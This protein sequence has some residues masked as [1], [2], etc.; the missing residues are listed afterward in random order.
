MAD[1]LNTYTTAH[2]AAHTHAH[3]TARPFKLTTNFTPQ[4]D[5][6]AAIDA[7]TEGLN[8]GLRDQVLLGVTGSG[9]T[10]T[11]ANVIERIQMPAL[12]IAHNK[13]LAAQL[14]GELKDLFQE[15]SVEYFVSYYDY[16]QPEAYIPRSDT[17][18]EK[19]SA[20]NDDIDRMRH[21]ATMAVLER[22]DAI[23]VASVSCIYGI[24]SPEDYL[25]MHLVVQEGAGMRRD[26]LVK[27]L[28]GLQY[29]REETEFRRGSL[30]V[31][32]DV[33]EVYPSFSQDKG[34]RIEFFGDD[35]D[36]LHEFDPMT[37]RRL[38]RLT[39]ASIYPNTHWVTPKHRIKAALPAI[40]AEMR[41]RV[42]FFK[43]QG[44]AVEAHRIAQRTMFDL[45]MLREFG[46]C[47]GIENYSRHLSGRAPG[48]P[49]YSLMDYFP[50]DFLVVIDE[51]HATVP[52]IGG[53]YEGDRSRKQTLIDYGFR[54]PSALDNR[55]LRFNE[56]EAR[57]RRV[58]YVS[59]TPG[60]YELEKSEGRVIEQII[61]PT[62]LIDPLVVI[63]PVTHQVEDL[64]G[65]IRN[66]LAAGE[67]VLATTL[68]KKMSED[69]C[70]YYTE[71]GIATKYLHSDID[72]L[73]RVKI[74]QELRL[75]VFDVLIGV[76]LLR[77]GLDLP[78]VS[79]VA[80]LDAD[81]EGFLRSVNSLIQ[82]A[83]R[84]ARN[85]NGTVILYADRLT[86]SIQRMMAETGRRRM[87]QLEYNRRMGITPETVR[88]E[89]KDVLASIYE[90][91]YWTVPVD[92]FAGDVL[93]AG[94]PRAGYGLDAETLKKLEEE[95]KDAARNLEFE[96][97][98][99][100]RDKIKAIRTKMLE[101][102]VK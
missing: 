38:G 96:R 77:E 48:Q 4:G 16:Y 60:K 6:P 54:L 64:L 31:R 29:R 52:Q 101:L 84:A 68:T 32:G 73:D 91:D 8:A 25:G 17:Y 58:I 67:R 3:A 78:E 46:F 102:G 27:R 23:I 20:I 43:R 9:K 24:G 18:I 51:S 92:P 5:Q 93:I 30:R 62:G 22:R 98:A 70:S 33:I 11:V 7:L 83:G 19:D 53:M 85:I 66:R 72:T 100:I 75:G 63:R 81:M 49:A 1:N 13:T 39:E 57:A 88:S 42:E 86:G 87:I 56:F 69:L 59:A 10:F 21:S 14:Y 15:N 47:S 55:P 28:V 61:R 89:I 40:E 74:L 99:V 37:G 79:L 45:E 12:V 34:I 26:E 94:E 2:A 36:A 80:V 95:M 76:N 50:D 41:D 65:E 35:I 44:R 97:A 71:L 82:T 90:A